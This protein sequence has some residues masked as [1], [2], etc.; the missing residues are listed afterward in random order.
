MR[1]KC[2]YCNN[3]IDDQDEKCPYCGASNSGL[4]RMG[5][6]VPQTIEQLKQWYI[7]HNLPDENTTRFF[8]GR[9][10]SGPK[11][12][13]I[14]KDESTGKI[15]VYKNK[16]DGTRATRYAGTD[17]AYAVNELYMKLKEEMINQKANSVGSR[18]SN[19][20]RPVNNI[21]Y[22]NIPKTNKSSSGNGWL[23]ALII[24]I[25]MIMI[26]SGIFMGGGR[27]YYSSGSSS[28]YSDYG[29][30]S[31]SDYGGSSSSSSSWSSSW[32]DDDW[33]SDWSSSSSWDSDWGSDWDS[34]W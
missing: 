31:Y 1:I 25:V 20:S 29:G 2:E 34:D 22:S 27:H 26:C 11:A 5:N 21:Q 12:Y 15:I 18:S 6:G 30:S 32:D 14:Y 8:I 24:I 10:Y 33:D 4:K 9:D 16:S 23:I 7:D 3:F 19:Y 28:G 17:E 13:G